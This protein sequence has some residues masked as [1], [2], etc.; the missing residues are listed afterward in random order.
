MINKQIPDENWCP[1]GQRWCL[2]DCML[3]INSGCHILRAIDNIILLA[4]A[5]QHKVFEEIEEKHGRKKAD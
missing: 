1:L 5:A 3:W 2:L 4:D